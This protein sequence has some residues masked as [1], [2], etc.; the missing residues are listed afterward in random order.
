MHSKDQIVLCTQ[1]LVSS[2]STL[3]LCL[4]TAPSKAMW[5]LP[6][7][8]IY[9]G[10]CYFKTLL[11]FFNNLPFIEGSLAALQFPGSHW[12]F[13]KTSIV[14]NN[15]G[16]LGKGIAVILIQVNTWQFI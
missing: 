7:H 16:F 13:L 5:N 12:N 3:G 9:P 1:W 2:K 14:F 15:V 6:L 11:S 8:Q 4:A 10:L